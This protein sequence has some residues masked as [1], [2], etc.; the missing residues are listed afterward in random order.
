MAPTTSFL[1]A[2][3]VDTPSPSAVPT[4]TSSPSPF[5][6]GSTLP[7]IPVWVAPI[8]GVVVFCAILVL[9][10]HARKSSRMWEEQTALKSQAKKPE[11]R[12]TFSQKMKKLFYGRAA[13]TMQLAPP[14]YTAPKQESAAQNAEAKNASSF[15]EKRMSATIATPPPAYTRTAAAENAALASPYALAHITRSNTLKNQRRAVQVFAKPPKVGEAP[16]QPILRPDGVRW[17]AEQDVE[18]ENSTSAGDSPAWRIA[19]HTCTHAMQ[20][21]THLTLWLEEEGTH[22]GTVNSEYWCRV[23]RAPTPTSRVPVV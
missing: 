21:C 6:N 12:R 15:S 18:K 7:N 2:R 3:D 14:A 4:P 1:I 19:G 13:S 5:D 22:S 9:F 23:P 10:Y 17:S 8:I 16:L 20:S 11:E